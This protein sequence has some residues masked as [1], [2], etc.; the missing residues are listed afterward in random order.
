[1][2][3]PLRTLLD[4]RVS[5][6]AIDSSDEAP[7]TEPIVVEGRLREDAVATDAGV[8]LRIDV[9]TVWLDSEPRHTSGSIAIGVG[10]GLQSTTAARWIAGRG[11]RLPAILRRPARYLNRG[12]D[13]QERALA[14]RGITLVGAVKSAALVEVTTRGRWWEELAA[15]VRRRTRLA[16]DRHVGSRDP[17]A[18][19]I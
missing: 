17:Q 6:F 15:R 14:R 19:A 2:H 5:G 9:S 13:D 1:M 16:L 18:A 3:A 4:E 10:G 11:V 8:T 12:L 7:S